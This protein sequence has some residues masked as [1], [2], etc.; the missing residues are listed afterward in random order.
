MNDKRF[1]WRDLQKHVD[2]YKGTGSRENMAYKM[3]L[4]GHKIDLRQIPVIEGLRKPYEIR[5]MIRK[6]LK[7]HNGVAYET[8][9]NKAIVW[10]PEAY[11]ERVKKE[12]LDRVF[13]KDYTSS[14]LS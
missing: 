4:A 1:N 10:F 2:H 7:G 3:L 9:E 8:D 13:K 11:E 12:M 6:I 5:R 14:G